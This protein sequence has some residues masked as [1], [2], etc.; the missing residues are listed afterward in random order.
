VRIEA[1]DDYQ[2]EIVIPFASVKTKFGTDV[3]VQ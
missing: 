3:N 2:L 1:L